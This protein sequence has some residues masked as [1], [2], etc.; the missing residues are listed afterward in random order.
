[1]KLLLWLLALGFAVFL[2]GWLL[3]VVIFAWI[4]AR[5]SDEQDP[6]PDADRS[7]ERQ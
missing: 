1:M 7:Q 2:V 3:F 4:G 5:V 6:G